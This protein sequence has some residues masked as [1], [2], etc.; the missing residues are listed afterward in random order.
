MEVK[1][2]SKETRYDMSEGA[3]EIGTVPEETR[4][5][6]GAAFAKG[7]AYMQMRDELGV[8]FEEADW[9]VLYSRLGQPG[10]AG[11]R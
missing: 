2:V 3:T 7:N 1:E 4:R 10:Y 6:A 8:L 9:R 5:V 11:W